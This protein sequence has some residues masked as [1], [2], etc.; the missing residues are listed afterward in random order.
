MDTEPTNQISS[1]NQSQINKI[2][3]ETNQNEQS[4]LNPQKNNFKIEIPKQISS[5]KSQKSSKRI[6]K[7]IQTN[8]DPEN[9]KESALNTSKE[10]TKVKKNLWKN[11]T[12][13]FVSY[14]EKNKSCLVENL[15]KKYTEKEIKDFFFHFKHH[16][17]KAKITNSYTFLKLL[18]PNKKQLDLQKHL[19]STIKHDIQIL[20]YKKMLR[21]LVLHF[22]NFDLLQ[23]CLLDSRV[24]YWNIFLQQRHFIIK[25]L[26][27]TQFV[28]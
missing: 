24:K 20:V 21:I 9:N 17:K 18:Y 7:Q 28:Q 23:S 11:L 14:F 6:K 12:R 4:Q 13:Q 2:D 26:K 19:I 27:T 3:F 1:L 10:I 5:K 25:L 8:N 15:Q 22:V 16:V